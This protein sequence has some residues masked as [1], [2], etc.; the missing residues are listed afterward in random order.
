ML[1]FNLPGQAD[2]EWQPEDVLN[3]DY[4]AAC[5]RA[6]LHYLGPNGVKQFLSTG[7]CPPFFLFG[8]GNGANV[9]ACTAMRYQ[10]EFPG[11]RALVA[12]NLFLHV[13]TQLAGI[14]HDSVNVFACSPATRLDLP[15]YYFSRFL[16]SKKYVDKVGAALALNLYS[17]V[18]NT[19]SNAG[20]IAI[21]R[22]ALA[23]ADLRA[24]LGTLSLPL[25]LI[26]SAADSLVNPAHSRYAPLLCVCVCVCAPTR[27]GVVVRWFAHTL[28]PVVT[29]FSPCRPEQSWRSVAIPLIQTAFTTSSP[30]S[31]PKLQCYGWTRVM[32]SCKSARR[33]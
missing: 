24:G 13:D 31:K 2:T 14:L 10:P 23:H 9:A 27:A 11:M 1:L 12:S 32:K 8:N 3:N 26:A 22:G 6:L 21:C 4:Y 5:T 20:R 18:G 19:I 25:I 28:L 30:R 15:V 16:F 17:A 33:L 29:T 7:I